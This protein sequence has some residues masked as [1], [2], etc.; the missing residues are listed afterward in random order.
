[1]GPLVPSQL[2]ATANVPGAAYAGRED[3]EILVR[4]LVGNQELDV[5][6]DLLQF[7]VGELPVLRG[8]RHGVEGWSSYL[9]FRSRITL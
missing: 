4:Y 9:N 3:A 6:L 2:L 7:S 5:L 1:M 8:S